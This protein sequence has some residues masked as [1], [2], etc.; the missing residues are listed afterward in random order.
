M[1]KKRRGVTLLEVMLVLSIL[2][3]LAA[4]AIPNIPSVRIR[5]EQ[6]VCIGNLWLIDTSKDQWALDTNKSS[7]DTVDWSDLYPDYLR[8]MPVCPATRSTDSYTLNSIGTDPT[9]TESGHVL[10]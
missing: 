10:E 2:A 8:E 6:K 5:T 1:E 3:L 7:G 9:C 4:M